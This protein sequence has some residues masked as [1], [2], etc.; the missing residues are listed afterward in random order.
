M[1]LNKDAITAAAHVYA[2]NE[3]VTGGHPIHAEVYSPKTK[4]VVD[5]YLAAMSAEGWK[6]VPRVMT[7][8]MK[9]AYTGTAIDPEYDWEPVFDAA[10]SP[11]TAP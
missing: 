5:A 2:V 6:L 9:E 3:N 4:K 10:P 7:A 11:D 8:E 1:S